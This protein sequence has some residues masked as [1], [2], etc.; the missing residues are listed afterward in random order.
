MPRLSPACRRPCWHVAMR[1]AQRMP[2]IPV[3]PPL[4]PSGLHMTEH[5]RTAGAV[6]ID[7]IRAALLLRPRGHAVQ[8]GPG[9]FFA[10][11][12][13]YAVIQLII[14]FSTSDEPRMLSPWGISTLLADTLLT[15]L[16]AWLLAVMCER[17][18]ITWGVASTA[19]A[20]TTAVSVLIQWPLDILVLRLTEDGNFDAAGWLYLLG[21]CW[22]LFALFAIARWLQPRRQLA[23]LAAAAVAFAVS[24]LPWQWIPVVPLVEQDYEALA[25]LENPTG[26]DITGTGF[27]EDSNTL[28]FN[29]EDLM[30]AQP[31]LMQNAIATLK[32]RTPGK[33]NLFVVAFA[34]DGSENVFRNE[35]EYA[36]LL[37]SSRFDAQ[38]HLLV[39]ENNPA[40]LE[41]RPLAT[42]TNLH[43]ALD[44]V[45][46]RMDPTEDILLLYVTSHGSKEHQ[47]LVGLDPLPLN[48]LTPEDIADALETSPSIRWKVLVINACYSGGFI[49]TLH[50]D[51]SMVITSARTDRTS[52]GCGTQSEIT[53]FG[54]A[55]LSEA[56]NQTTSI[57]AAFTQASASIT[58]WETDAGIETHSE[59]QLASSSSIEAKLESWSRSLPAR[60]PIPFAPADGAGN[61]PTTGSGE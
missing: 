31:L 50:D 41:T 45:A 4:I 54:R 19:L 49:D 32:P 38:G 12:A 40:S 9:M 53:Y 56:L 22:W 6:V 37:F 16:A 13:L 14:G 35:V 17:R 2:V 36:S 61:G 15:L 46:A 11:L 55:F 59:P 10:M 34:G 42:L 1:V 27:E 29:P 25:A 8:S 18:A 48:Q 21:R 39:L 24:A 23:N 28:A 30:Y 33:P 3:S 51:S 26:D 43:I 57:P 5:L 44:A 47:V 60:A 52:F 7:G 58:Q 20:A